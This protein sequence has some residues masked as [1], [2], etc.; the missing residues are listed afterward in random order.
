MKIPFA[1][2]VRRSPAYTRPSVKIFSALL[3]QD[4]RIEAK[5]GVEWRRLAVYHGQGSGEAGAPGQRL[6][7]SQHFIESGRDESAVHATRGSLVG[8]AELDA[9][10][11]AALAGLA[12][13]DRRRQGIGESDHWALVEEGTHVA[14]ESA[15]RE[16]LVSRE[17][18]VGGE[19][20][21]I[22]FESIGGGSQFPFRR[23]ASNQSSN[24][25]SHG[26][27]QAPL[28]FPG[29]ARRHR[30]LPVAREIR[31]APTLVA[32]G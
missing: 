29:A 18:I 26:G 24:H 14:G 7:E 25:Q 28:L 17:L 8:R 20:L 16:S 31:I 5:L 13:R 1:S 19:L 6:G 21:G 4:L 11:G 30:W 32:H 9:S 12:D 22:A 23:V 27:R 3:A 10:F 15:F 2:A